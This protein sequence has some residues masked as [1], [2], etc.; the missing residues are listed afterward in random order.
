MFTFDSSLV[1]F[2]AGQLRSFGGLHTER[3]EGRLF[4]LIRK[5]IIEGYFSDVRH[6][7]NRDYESWK[8]INLNSLILEKRR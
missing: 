6:K 7:G 5:R 8:D 4:R 2:V 3:A 1:C